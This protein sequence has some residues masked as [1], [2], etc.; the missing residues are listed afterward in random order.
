MNILN[1]VLSPLNALSN[2]TDSELGAAL[3]GFE[4]EKLSERLIGFTRNFATVIAVK[5]DRFLKLGQKIS[6]DE[7]GGAEFNVVL[8]SGV[9]TNEADIIQC[10][11]VA[12][13]ALQIE[14][15]QTLL[16]VSVGCGGNSAETAQ[17]TQFERLFILSQSPLVSK[18][19][20]PIGDWFVDNSGGGV[21]VGANCTYEHEGVLKF[22]TNSQRVFLTYEADNINWHVKVES[23]T[24]LTQGFLGGGYVR[25]E[26]GDNVQIS[27]WS[28]SKHSWD[29]LKLVKCTNSNV[30]D[31]RGVYGK[32]SA[33]TLEGCENTNVYNNVL[34][35]NGRNSS[36]DSF[37][38]MPTGW[39]GS[40]VGRGVTLV[41]SSDGTP[42][43]NCNVYNNNAKNNSEYGIRSFGESPKVGNVECDIYDNY[44]EDNGAPAGDYGGAT[45]LEAKGVDILINGSLTADSLQVRVLNNRIKR[46]LAFGG[47]LSLSGTEPE[48][49]GNRIRLIGEA[50]H[51]VDAIQLFNC[52][53]PLLTGNRSFG[54]AKHVQIASGNIDLELV[55]DTAFD[56]ISFLHAMPG[57]SNNSIRG[58]R[59]FHRTTTAVGGE[60]GILF[61]ATAD[62][63]DNKMDG[64]FYGI[65]VSGTP[66]GK[67]SNNTTTNSANA[68]LRNFAVDSDLVLQ[69][70]ND[71]DSQNPFEKSAVVYESTTERAGGL[72]FAYTIPTKGY[73]KR[74]HVVFDSQPDNL[75]NGRLKL[76][77]LRLRFG[78]GHILNTDWQ[79]LWVESS[80]T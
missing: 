72:S 16:G 10:V 70:D 21:A 68:G 37:A 61:S 33:V 78:T 15:K 17:S 8:A 38:D 71:F 76:G 60:N 75:N 1:N 19:I 35:N 53:R 28:V 59:G 52:K 56:C 36:D 47:A 50:K 5:S 11:G 7:R 63:H 2:K 34:N 13:L 40:L 69:S 77:W 67:L 25:F 42:C 41:A 32:S 46:S 14:L 4:G 27:D 6:I 74:G 80:P 55:N 29:G 58:N 57:G 64:F 3:I 24:E 62:I 65:E 30:F 43:T 48:A 73:Y 31:G 51:V 18:V 49:K 79:E 12:S 9:T 26:N 45:G 44:V 23:T 66:S 20:L 54:A 22:N 39:A